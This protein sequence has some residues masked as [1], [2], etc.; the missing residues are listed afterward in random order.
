M[1]QHRVW[2]KIIVGLGCFI[3]STV[4][5]LPFF[6]A[7]RDALNIAH[8][9][10]TA[11][12]IVNPPGSAVAY[13]LVWAD[14]LTRPYPEVEAV[15]VAWVPMDNSPVELDYLPREAYDERY[16]PEQKSV[17]F[18]SLPQT[19]RTAFG[20]SVVVD[21][22]DL[23]SLAD[24][25]GGVPIGNQTLTASDMVAYLTP[26]STNTAEE[27]MIRQVAVMQGLIAQLSL[28]GRNLNVADVLALAKHKTID[29]G[30]LT[31]VVYKYY[32]LQ[33][34]SVHIRLNTHS[35]P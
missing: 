8:P 25:V 35:A 26:N 32:P 31:A 14:D 9:V 30:V 3:L 10:P 22:A 12:H 18:E 21:R 11:T 1:N 29:D 19:V 16:I 15:W 13:V 20:G 28:R 5:S 7:W 23:C 34:N 24:L 27:M 6:S 33:M 17:A 2:N 4:I